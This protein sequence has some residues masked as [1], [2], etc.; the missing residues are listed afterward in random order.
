MGVK[1]S[2]ADTIHIGG[3]DQTSPTRFVTDIL[4][5][6]S[7]STDVKTEPDDEHSELH[8]PSLEPIPGESQTIEPDAG[9]KIVPLS[10]FD[11]VKRHQKLP[12]SIRKNYERRNVSGGLPQ[13]ASNA[14]SPDVN[15]VT[16]SIVRRSSRIKKIATPQSSK[17]A[18]RTKRAVKSTPKT[19][20]ETGPGPTVSQMERPAEAK[21]TFHFFLMN[22]NF[23]VFPVALKDCNTFDLF[24]EEAEKAWKFQGGNGGKNSM[25]AV[26]LDYD[27]CSYPMNVR[28]K[29]AQM[30]ERM[31]EWVETGEAATAEAGRVGD[32]VVKVKC[33]RK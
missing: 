13:R 25:V 20:L 4:H 15:N 18:K 27:G 17:T 24:F 11:L 5:E 31:M 30:Y 16:P 7:S 2:S 29:D 6:P 14:D 26:M 3:D 32:L 28:W 12:L 8:N 9:P 22:E 19:T 10:S 21:V 33:I 1:S 23:G